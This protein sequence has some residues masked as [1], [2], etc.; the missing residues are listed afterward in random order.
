MA[1]ASPEADD[2]TLYRVGGLAALGI[3]IGYV[4]IIPIFLAVGAPPA[5]AEA[6]LAYLAGK[7]APWWAILGLSVVTDLLFV[8][9]ALALYGALRRI[10]RNTMALA[11]TLMLLFVGVDLAVTWTNYAVLISVADGYAVAAADAER[12]AQ[13]AAA[14]SASVLLSSTL[15]AAYSIGI[16]A[17]AILL[18]G[19][20]SYQSNLGRSAAWLAIAT[21]I[22]GIV[23]VVGTLLVRGIGA[24]A[25]LASLLT[26]I[27]LFV[28]GYR[29][30]Q[31]ARAAGPRAPDL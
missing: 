7:T 30:L 20:V 13:L 3:G 1:T 12:T 14:T 4:V 16:L 31:M 21:G 29:L 11:A 22:L 25:I 18:I 27:W 17:V 15:E 19:I 24:M 8:P 5:G 10:D 26:T 28:V 6:W 9:L 23:A 2:R